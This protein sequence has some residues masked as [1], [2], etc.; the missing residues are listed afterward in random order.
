MDS[1]ETAPILSH[2]KIPTSARGSID[3][4]RH[5]IQLIC[6]S[7]RPPY[8]PGAFTDRYQANLASVI[9]FIHPTDFP[10]ISMTANQRPPGCKFPPEAETEIPVQA[11]FIEQRH[12]KGEAERAV[13]ISAGS[14]LEQVDGLPDRNF[15]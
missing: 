14:E 10:E 11:A 9:C 7:T 12:Q 4:Y 2:Q 3:S 1:Y 15:G 13:D 5:Q 8:T 6:H